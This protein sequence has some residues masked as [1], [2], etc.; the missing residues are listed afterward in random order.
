MWSKLSIFIV[1]KTHVFLVVPEGGYY[2]I[3]VLC[4][5]V[6]VNTNYSASGGSKICPVLGASH[7]QMFNELDQCSIFPLNHDNYKRD[8]N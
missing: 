5:S 3:D 7:V 8:V 1:G 6:S 4:T 2:M